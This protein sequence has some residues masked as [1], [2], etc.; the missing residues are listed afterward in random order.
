MSLPADRPEAQADWEV[1]PEG[2][3][4]ATRHFLLRRGYCCANRCRN[5]P[6]INWHAN[7]TWQ[8]APSQAIRRATVTPKA[9]ATARA[10]LA[11][12]EQALHTAHKDEQAYHGEMIGHYR[13]LLERW[14]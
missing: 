9:L 14:R 10:A 8:H 2:L 11:H 6:Y 3:Y 1:T 7:P 4:I 5:C 12:H 13:V